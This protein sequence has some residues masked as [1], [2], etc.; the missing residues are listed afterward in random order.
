MYF[1]PLCR[2]VSEPESRIA[3]AAVRDGKLLHPSKPLALEAASDAVGFNF[4][5]LFSTRSAPG[6]LIQRGW[7]SCGQLYWARYNFRNPADK[8]SASFFELQLN[9][10]RI[11]SASLFSLRGST[12]VQFARK[13]GTAA[14]SCRQRYCSPKWYATASISRF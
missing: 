5:W 13:I 1:P 12:R 3:P 6:S 8:F 4:C 10:P 14:D 11:S 7:S 9:A 2:I